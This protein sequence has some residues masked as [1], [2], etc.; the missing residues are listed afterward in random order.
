MQGAA[1]LITNKDYL[2]AAA[3]IMAVEAY[4]AGAVRFALAQSSS[5]I[6]IPYG[7]PISA[8]TGVSIILRVFSFE[9]SKPDA[10]Y[11]IWLVIFVH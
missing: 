5:R 2:T 3:G 6:V 10:V 4:H 11:G 1:P 7:A 9:S 8:V